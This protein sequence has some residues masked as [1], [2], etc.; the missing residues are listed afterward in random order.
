[1]NNLKQQYQLLN[2]IVKYASQY[3]I[4]KPLTIQSMAGAG[5][6]LL[7]KNCKTSKTIK[8]RSTMTYL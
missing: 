7:K 2:A 4:T 6:K 8:R 3:Y 5:K 1:M